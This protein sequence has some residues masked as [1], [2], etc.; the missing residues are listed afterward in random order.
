MWDQPKPVALFYIAAYGDQMKIRA[1]ILERPALH[2]PA[3][4]YQDV[5][6]TQEIY[7]SLSHLKSMVIAR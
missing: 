7:L 1:W 4:C 5:A 6:P 3:Q 2:P